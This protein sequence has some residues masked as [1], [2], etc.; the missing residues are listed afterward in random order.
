MRGVGRANTMS[1]RPAWAWLYASAA[2][3]LAPFVL[4]VTH[5]PAGAVR[6]IIEVVAAL[7]LIGTLALWVRLNR[8]ALEL[9]G[10]R[11]SGWREAI[12]TANASTRPVDWPRQDQENLSRRPRTGDQPAQSVGQKG[13]R[14]EGFA[15]VSRG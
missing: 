9:Q 4:V 11:D 12:V 6:T 10:R 15:F 2:L 7:I 3:A 13:P 1:R 14:H 5:V 8:I